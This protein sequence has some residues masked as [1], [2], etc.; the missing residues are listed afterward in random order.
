MKKKLK[1]VVVI[2]TCSKTGNTAPAITTSITYTK[3]S[4][5][6]SKERENAINEAKNASKLADSQNWQF[7]IKE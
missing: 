1:F 6:S 4:D 2:P 5:L 3:I 7:K